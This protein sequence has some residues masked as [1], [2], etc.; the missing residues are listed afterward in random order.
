M[1]ASEFWTNDDG[2]N[3][4]FGLE[5]GASAKSGHLNTY[6]DEREVTFAIT[7]TDITSSDALH[8]THP[9]TSIPD[10]AHIISATLY[11]TAAFTSGGAATLDIGLWNDDGDGTFSVNDANGIDAA[12]AITVLDAVGDHLA[13]DGALVGSGA[14]AL[15]GTGDRPLF[16]SI[17]YGTAAYTAGT[18]DLVIKYRV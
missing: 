7:A 17:S 2:L 10:G 3:I 18:A 13:C 4:R 5:K 14:A 9:L 12:V 1:S 16:L 11:I 8:E 6:G 15:A